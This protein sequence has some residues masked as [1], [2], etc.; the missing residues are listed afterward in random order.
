MAHLAGVT[1]AEVVPVLASEENVVQILE[2]VRLEGRCQCVR[3]WR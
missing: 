2:K 1:P 3:L